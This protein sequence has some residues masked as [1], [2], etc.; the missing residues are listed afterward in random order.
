MKKIFLLFI[1]LSFVILLTSCLSTSDE[2][3][4]HEMVNKFFPNNEFFVD[5]AIVM[6]PSSFD[7]NA[8]DIYFDYE[9]NSDNIKRGKPV[10]K[11]DI[12]YYE[13]EAVITD[14]KQV[15]DA[16][17][18]ITYSPSD[19]E[20][21]YKEIKL[22]FY[23]TDNKSFK[24]NLYLSSPN[25]TVLDNGDIKYEHKTENEKTD[26]IRESWYTV[27]FNYSLSNN[28]VK[29]EYNSYAEIYSYTE[30]RYVTT[31][32]TY[33]I[34]IN[35]NSRKIIYNNILEIS[36]DQGQEQLIDFESKHIKNINSL[37][38]KISK[39]DKAA[40]IAGETKYISIF[41]NTSYKIEDI[42]K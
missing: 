32:S 20:Y 35:Y 33:E 18:K 8:I 13:Y 38:D 11:G 27:K 4:I 7:V 14:V 25:Y 30:A 15:V 21:K 37:L 5:N 31:R 40:S 9:F 1:N 16:T 23:I 10:R 12:Y 28:I 29:Y 41:A 22:K 19:A 34:E 42:L 3:G 39:I 26:L 2:A 17:L 6:L 24:Y 36:L